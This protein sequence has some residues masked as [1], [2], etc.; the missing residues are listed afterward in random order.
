MD[1]LEAMRGFVLAVEEGSLAAAG[2]RLGR[3]PA[4]MTRALEF[5][6]RRIGATLLQRTTRALRLTQAGERYLATC[7]QVLATLEAAERAAGGEQAELR[8][9][10]TL[11]SPATFGRLHVRPIVD[12]FLAAHSGMRVR[13]LLLDRIVS[14]LEEGMDAAIRI[15]QL[16]DSSLT[17]VR[18]GEV[19]RLVVASPAY[20]A[21]HGLPKRPQDLRDHACIVISGTATDEIWTFGRRRVR[22]EPRLN[23][24][25]AQ[26]AVASAAEGHGITRLLSYQVER[27]MT[28]GKLVRI[29]KEFEPAPLPV[30]IVTL[31]ARPT[32]ARLAAFTAFAVPALR[33]MLKRVEKAVGRTGS[34]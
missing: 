30:Q 33:A 18:A 20:L 1:R 17:A 19:R 3:S 9:L 2:R 5:L 15:G 34:G 14:L 7:R 32:P 28:A 21:R 8:G 26:S 29:L 12:A 11:T 16:P 10:L 25:D 6:E 4:A 27:E 24:N 13:L 23:L 22:L 31:P